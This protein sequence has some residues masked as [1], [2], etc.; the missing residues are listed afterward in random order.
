MFGLAIGRGPESVRGTSY[1]KGT[2]AYQ[3]EYEKFCNLLIPGEGPINDV[4]TMLLVVNDVYT[5]VMTRSGRPSIHKWW[6]KNKT[7][8]FFNDKK[9]VADFN[10]FFDKFG[11]MP[12]SLLEGTLHRIVGYLL[13]KMPWGKLYENVLNYHTDKGK[14]QDDFATIYAGLAMDKVF[15]NSIYGDMHR[16]AITIYNNRLIMNDSDFQNWWDERIPAYSCFGTQMNAALCKLAEC[17]TGM[18]TEMMMDEI[19]IFIKCIKEFTNLPKTTACVELGELEDR[20]AQRLA[21]HLFAENGIKC[22]CEE[23]RA[24]LCYALR[25][26]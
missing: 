3:A 22:P 15:S 8:Y 11:N 18:E 5:Y 10:D 26:V 1:L 20:A 16:A 13:V 24:A 4:G 21:L 14:H 2:G 6:E 9:Y 23:L 7:E 17:T 25:V 19:I 12:R